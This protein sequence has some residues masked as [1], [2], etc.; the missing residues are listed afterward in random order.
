MN[1]FGKKTNKAE[2]AKAIFIKA[3]EF[4]ASGKLVEA[5]AAYKEH[6]KLSHELGNA[7]GEITSMMGQYNMYLRLKQGSDAK[8]ILEKTLST[9]KK[10]GMTQ[11]VAMLSTLMDSY[12]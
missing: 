5:L 9:A 1:I 10:N 11:H 4:D 3:K 2:E 7:D 12:R 8:A 6:E